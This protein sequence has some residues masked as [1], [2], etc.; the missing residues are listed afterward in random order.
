MSKVW[1]G[2]K[3]SS[4]RPIEDRKKFEN[5]WDRIFDKTTAKVHQDGFK[6]DVEN[7]RN[8]DKSKENSL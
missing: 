3:G 6:C 7:D 5:N 1:H 8:N 4:A 2:G